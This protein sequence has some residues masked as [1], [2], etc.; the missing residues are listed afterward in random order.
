[1]PCGTLGVSGINQFVHGGRDKKNVG[2]H[3]EPNGVRKDCK[4]GHQLPLC[5]RKACGAGTNLLGDDFSGK[6]RTPSYLASEGGG[7]S[8]RG[9]RARFCPVGNRAAVPARGAYTAHGGPAI[10][11]L[12]NNG[13]WQK[14]PANNRVSSDGEN[15][16]HNQ[17]GQNVNQKKTHKG[18]PLNS[19]RTTPNCFSPG[20]QKPIRP[21]RQSF[22]R[23]QRTGHKTEGTADSGPVRNIYRVRKR[24]WFVEPRPTE[25]PGNSIC[26]ERHF[27]F[28]MWRPRVKTEEAKLKKKGVPRKVQKA[29]RG[30]LRGW[31][32]VTAPLPLHNAQFEIVS[33]RKKITQREHTWPVCKTVTGPHISRKKKKER[34]EKSPWWKTKRQF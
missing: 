19:N 34:R 12:D 16:T 21:T 2:V 33:G 25:G 7:T 22:D 31:P 30:A 4:L 13:F 28:P 17:E 14:T 18:G 8:L 29:L 3:K 5:S 15:R 10:K 20:N 23:G 32:Q 27:T 6:T 24:R 1:V 11:T 26:V 9:K